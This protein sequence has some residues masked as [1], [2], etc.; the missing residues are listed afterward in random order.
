MD[1][2]NLTKRK[3]I[4]KA[5]TSI[6]IAVSAAAF[7]TV[8]SLVATKVL[9]SQISYQNRVIA[10][11]RVANDTLRKNI[12]TSEQ[13]KDSYDAF[14]GTTQNVI[15]GLAT[16]TEPKD[17]ANPKI[18][19]DALPSSYDF[20][21]LTTNLELLATQ[22]A[23]LMS[24]TGTDDQVAQSSNTSS[25]TPEPVAMPFELT[26]SG[27]YDQIRNMVSASERSIRPI[28]Y[29]SMEVSGE[30][31]ELTLRVTAETYYQPAKSLQGRMDTV[32]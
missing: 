22:N 9:V 32:R 17:G 2:A 7:L 4:D 12:A 10:K 30:K 31:E 13:L 6:V 28:K 3:L 29:T 11:Q 19:L 8:F 20:P 25:I 18:I 15:G 14:A 24:I 16:G 5:N 23:K 21:A 1:V 27:S 26:V